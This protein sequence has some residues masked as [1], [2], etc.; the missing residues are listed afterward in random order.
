MGEAVPNKGIPP[1]SVQAEG[2]RLDPDTG[3]PLPNPYPE[4]LPCPL[5]GEPEVEVWCNQKRVMCHNCGGWFDHTP[6][7]NCN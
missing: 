7:E 5:C 1:E 6:T 2:V 4:Y 3:L